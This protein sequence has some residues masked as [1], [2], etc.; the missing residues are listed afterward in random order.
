MLHASNSIALE[1]TQCAPPTRSRVP[2]E[3]KRCRP[4]RG[5]PLLKSS[6][7][8]S[9]NSAARE[10]HA[11]YLCPRICAWAQACGSPPR[12]AKSRRA[13]LDEKGKVGLQHHCG[14]HSS[15]GTWRSVS[16]RVRSN[17]A[18]GDVDASWE[19]LGVGEAGAA[20]P[21]VTQARNPSGCSEPL[22]VYGKQKMPPRCHRDVQ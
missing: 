1:T 21:G 8:Y 9:R 20:R 22:R 2:S 18:R 7:V 3:Q 13:V 15:R 14:H 12:A 16:K 17:L 5:K 10:V 4:S 6:A 19:L 11:C